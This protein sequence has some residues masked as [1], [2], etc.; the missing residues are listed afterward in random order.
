MEREE[1]GKNEIEE[2]LTRGKIRIEGE[3]DNLEKIKR[4]KNISSN[5]REL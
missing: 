3:T 1:I 2:A 4:I 5:V